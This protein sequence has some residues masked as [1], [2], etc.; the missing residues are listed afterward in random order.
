MFSSSTL[1]GWI[2]TNVIGGIWDL[3]NSTGG[4]VFTAFGVLLG[5]GF[6]IHLVRKY[7]AKRKV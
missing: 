5:V 7:I 6:A 1:A 2:T 4:Q 3:L